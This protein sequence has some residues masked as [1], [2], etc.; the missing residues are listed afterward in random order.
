MG[1]SFQLWLCARSAK[2]TFMR[3]LSS[4]CGE[5]TTGDIYGRGSIEVNGLSCGKQTP[6]VVQVTSV[7]AMTWEQKNTLLNHLPKIFGI[8][9]GN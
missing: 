7:K 8:F 3:P 4:Q 6:P 5:G 2:L 9:S 1:S